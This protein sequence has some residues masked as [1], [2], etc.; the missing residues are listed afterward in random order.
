MGVKME[1][2]QE[3]TLQTGKYLQYFPEVNS[4][5]CLSK[6]DSTSLSLFL[7]RSSGRPDDRAKENS[8]GNINP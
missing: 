7:S 6:Y 4:L 5:V 8:Q 3:I 1:S 2:R